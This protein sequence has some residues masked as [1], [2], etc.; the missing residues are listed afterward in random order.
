[1]GTKP[2]IASVEGDAFGAGCSIAI[3]CDVVVATPTSRFG[4]SFGKIGLVPDMG[5]LYTLVQRIGRPRAARMMMLATTA[6]GAEAVTTGLADELA[7]PGGALEH[8]M[9]IARQYE[10]VAPMSVALIKSAL[11]SHIASVEDVIR[12]ELDLVPHATSS[13]SEEQP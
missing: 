12:T 8:A 9:K 7:E 3:A 6:S 1:M 4:T 2:M 5:M 10:A 13:R 11:G